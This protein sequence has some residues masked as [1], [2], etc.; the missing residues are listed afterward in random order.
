MTMQRWIKRNPMEATMVGIGIGIALLNSG[1][2]RESLAKQDALRSV[3]ATNQEQVQTQQILEQKQ[4]DLRPIAEARYNDGCLLVLSFDDK[5]RYK[6]L[7]VGSPVI[8]GNVKLRL[9]PGAKPPI[10]AVL[11][12]GSTVC[13]AYGNTSILETDEDGYPIVKTIA[14][15]PNQAIVLK[16]MQ[17]V[18]G[19]RSEVLK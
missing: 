6:V 15:T 17:K 4:K 3:V 9:R 10:S 8:D 13:D 12:A 11:P 19:I 5:R 16:A 1:G 18:R 2:I 14:S 7:T